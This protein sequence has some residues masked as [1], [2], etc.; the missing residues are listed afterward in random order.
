[1]TNEKKVS[2][3]RPGNEREE[4]EPQRLTFGMH[5]IC[6]TC[7]GTGRLG[8]SDKSSACMHCSGR[9]FVPYAGM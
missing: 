4:P 9:G 7:K 8:R 1:M 5:K 2:P 6:T 3:L